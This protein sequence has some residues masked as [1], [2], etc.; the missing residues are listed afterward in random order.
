MKGRVRQTRRAIQ[1]VT[2]KK[3][4]KI[5]ERQ[6]FRVHQIDIHDTIPI[7]FDISEI[8]S[9]DFFTDG[10]RVFEDVGQAALHEAR[11]RDME[12]YDVVVSEN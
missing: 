11:L 6:V 2:S 1:K 7:I 4:G 9:L 5:R 12:D 3:C 10:M 8:Y